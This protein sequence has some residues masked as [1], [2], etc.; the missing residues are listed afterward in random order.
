MELPDPK[1]PQ[2][3]VQLS[4]PEGNLFAVSERGWQL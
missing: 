1:A 4:D 2:T 3:E